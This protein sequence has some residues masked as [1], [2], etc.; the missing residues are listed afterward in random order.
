MPGR[1]L[2]ARRLQAELLDELRSVALPV[3]GAG[4]VCGT[5]ASSEPS[6]TTS[7]T[8]SSRAR[9]DD[10]PRERAPAQVRLDPEQQHGV[11]VGARRSARGR[12]RSR[13]SRSGGSSPRRARR[14]AASPGSRR[15]PPGRS[16][17]SCSALPALREVAAGERWRPGRRRSSR[18][19]PRRARAARSSGASEMRSS[20]PS[21]EST[22]RRERCG[23]RQSTRHE[24]DRRRPDRRRERDVDEHEPHGSAFRHWISPT[25]ICASRS[26]RSTSR[27]RRA[28]P[29]A[30]RAGAR[31][32]RARRG[33]A[34][35]K[36]AVA[37]TWT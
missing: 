33:S 16:P 6:V 12:R 5:S 25:A 32:A 27:D 3:T 22:S 1:P 37:R 15:S 23:G 7:S 21:A 24:R 9:P 31:A 20:S 17:R 34:I 19:T 30:A 14:A 26:A 29:G 8:P 18:G 10:E 4:R 28:A 13:A 11:A 36:T 35:P 2:V